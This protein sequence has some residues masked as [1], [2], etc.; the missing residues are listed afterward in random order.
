MVGGGVVLKTLRIFCVLAAASLSGCSLLPGSG[1]S[2]DAVM[3]AGTPSESRP[4]TA[5][6]LVEIDTNVVA[7]LARHGAP[8]LRG[9]FGDY[10]PPASQPI[11]IGDTLQITLWEA[12]SGGLFS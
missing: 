11:G 9:S 7:A 1:P 3:T 2:G 5:F 4:E 8:G 10:R 12:A 6:A